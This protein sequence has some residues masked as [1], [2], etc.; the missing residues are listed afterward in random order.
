MR[1]SILG[2]LRFAL[3]ASVALTTASCTEQTALA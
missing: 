3:A 1:P 2:S